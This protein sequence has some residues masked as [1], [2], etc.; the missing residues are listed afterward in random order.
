[1]N[2]GELF[3]AAARF[4]AD[5]KYIAGDCEYCAGGISKW[6]PYALPVLDIEGVGTVSLPLSGDQVQRL[7]DV[8]IQS[9]Y[10]QGSETVVDTSV[11]NSFQIDASKINFTHPTWQTGFASIMREAVKNLGLRPGLVSS[12]LY[13]L[14]LYEEGGHFKLHR[15]SE[16]VQGMFATL[17]VQLPTTFKGGAYRA[18]A[19]LSARWIRRDRIQQCNPLHRPLLRL[20]ALGRAPHL[21]M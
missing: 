1:M 11:R 9:P 4:A 10:G 20:R 3:P 5:F 6:Q 19:H 16:K 18:R 17:V 8:A 13:K 7:K 15:D 21:R 12:E 2:E 14:L